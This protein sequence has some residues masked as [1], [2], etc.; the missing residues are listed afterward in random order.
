MMTHRNASESLLNKLFS[1]AQFGNSELSN[2]IVMAPMTRDFATDGVVGHDVVDYYRRRVEGGVGLI[3][4]EGTLIDHVGANA[5]K[6]QIPNFYGENALAGWKKVVEA[7]HE[8]GGH[9]IPQLWHTGA[10]RKPGGA[11]MD[12]SERGYGPMDIYGIDANGDKGELECKGMTQ[13][14]IN[15]VIQAYVQA[16]IDAENLGFDGIEIHG[17]HGYLIDQF[18]WEEMNQR[19]DQYGGSLENRIRFAVEIVKAVRNAVNTNFPI[20]F[21]FSQW[22]QQD[23]SAKIAQTP[24][25]LSAIVNALSEAGVDIFHAST[26]RFWEPAFDNSP[27]TLA[28]WVR[29]IT[30]KPV[31]AVGS[32]GLDTQFGWEL[33]TQPD[34]KHQS[35]VTNVER[36]INDFENNDFDFIAVGRALIADAQWPNKVQAGR[37]DEIVPFQREQ[38]DSLV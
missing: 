35:E 15:E 8:A 10:V 31:I 30:N 32:V 18:F 9:I 25:E 1:P 38:L 24:K 33:W 13:Q 28:A 37:F 17:A 12:P 14:D 2:R 4:T 11:G 5:Y 19:N 3:I 16:A 34:E 23:Y 20:V 21:R 26:R 7:V 6:E 36:L 22:K 27:L 29:K